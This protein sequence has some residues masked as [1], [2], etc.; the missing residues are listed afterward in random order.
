LRRRALAGRAKRRPPVSL[1]E[2]GRRARTNPSSR[3]PARVHPICSCAYRLLAA[4]RRAPQW[5]MRQVAHHAARP[6]TRAC[7]SRWCCSSARVL[8]QD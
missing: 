6:G 5:A 1:T 2:A 3:V 8:L 7:C 4:S